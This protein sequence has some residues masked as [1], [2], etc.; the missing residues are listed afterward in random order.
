MNS[1]THVSLIVSLA[2]AFAFIAA[3]CQQEGPAEQTGQ[4]ID[5]AVEK[6]GEKMEAAKESLDE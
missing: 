1:S 4:K 5:Q 6:A 3:G 2:L